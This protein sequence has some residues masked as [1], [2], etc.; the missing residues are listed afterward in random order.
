MVNLPPDVFGL[1]A[2]IIMQCATS[3]IVLLVA[4]VVLFVTKD[5]EIK[6]WAIGAVG[7][8]LG[9]WLR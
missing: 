3:A 6:F 1:R 5:V 4:L 7:T 9:Y 2:K 8:V